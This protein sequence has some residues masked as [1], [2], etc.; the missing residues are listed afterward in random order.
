MLSEFPLLF[1]KLHRFERVE[2][3]TTYTMSV[4][5]FFTYLKIIHESVWRQHLVSFHVDTSSCTFAEPYLA[6]SPSLGAVT[7]LVLLQ[8]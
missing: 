1:A 3:S 2:T 8:F 6:F 7:W 5:T 4:P